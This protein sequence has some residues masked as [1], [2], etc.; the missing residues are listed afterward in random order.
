M[1]SRLAPDTIKRPVAGRASYTEVILLDGDTH[2]EEVVTAEATDYADLMWHP[3]RC[4]LVEN[5]AAN[6]VTFTVEGSPDKTNWFTIAYGTS[7]TPFTQD[8]LVLAAD[9]VALLF[10]ATD[11]YV[12]YM[13][14]VPSVANANGTTF[15]VFAEGGA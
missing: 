2:A 3:R 15:T 11:D 12:R 7:T 10:F 4:M 8:P 5:D 13:R 1:P 14:V 9:E 6:G